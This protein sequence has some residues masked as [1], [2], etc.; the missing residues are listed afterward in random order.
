MPLL[1]S[2]QLS[3]EERNEEFDQGFHQ[4]DR[5]TLNNRLYS[6]DPNYPTDKAYD[7]EAVFEVA[8]EYFS[9]TRLHRHLQ[10]HLR[11]NGNLK[12]SD[13]DH[14]TQDYRCNREERD[15]DREHE[16]DLDRNHDRDYDHQRSGDWQAHDHHCRDDGYGYGYDWQDRSPRHDYDRR[17]NRDGGRCYCDSSPSPDRD[18]DHDHRCDTDPSVQ[19][20]YTTKTVRFQEPKPNNDNHEL[21]DLISK[22]HSLSIRD[23]TYVTLYAQCMNCF[24]NVAQKLAAL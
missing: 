11:D 7:L 5:E 15:H 3:N 8:Q 23:A 20:E 6:K 10:R 2:H 24:P 1:D 16:C 14:S 21:S 12:Y 22:M 9:N 13:T 17:D 19:Q 4:T 18:R